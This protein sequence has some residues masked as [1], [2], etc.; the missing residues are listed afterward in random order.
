MKREDNVLKLYKWC[1]IIAFVIV[2]FAAVL[3]SMRTPK[4]IYLCERAHVVS[5]GETLWGICAEY[6]PECMDM[7]EYI[8]I[9]RK[10][11]CAGDVIYPGDIITVF[12]EVLK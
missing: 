5:A 2:L 6:K 4:A 9:C 8:T 1:G 3:V 11:S 12:T 7:G 10:A